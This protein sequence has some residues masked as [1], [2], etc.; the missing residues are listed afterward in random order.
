MRMIKPYG[1]SETTLT[2]GQ[3][4]RR[5]LRPNTP[6]DTPVNI[7]EYAKTHPE[8]IIAQWISAI[9]KIAAKPHGDKKP[10]PEQRQFRQRL[11][12]AAFEV[13]SNQN[14]LPLPDRKDEL[15]GLWWSKIHPYGKDDDT[16]KSG[17]EK[18]RWYKRF[19]GG[20][21]PP[22]ADPAAIAEKI[23]KHLHQQE[24][25]IWPDRPDKRRGRIEARA[26]SIAESVPALP[27]AF[28][29]GEHPWS[30]KDKE[31]YKTAGNIAHQIKLKHEARKKQEEER[32]FSMRDAAPILFEQYGRLF[33]D[34]NGKALPVAGARERFP[35]LFALHSAV[36]D[37]YARILETHRPLTGKKSVTPVFPPDM[38]ALFRLLRAKAD[39]R[40]LNA[41]TRLGKLIH[42]QATPSSG[43]DAPG[44]V[45]DHWPADVEHSQ[46]RTSAG[47]AEIKRHEAFVRVWRNTIALAARTLKDWADPDG[48]IG[49]DILLQIEKAIK[50]FRASAY[51]KKL[52]LLFGNRSDLFKGQDEDFQK[53]VLRLALKGWADLRNASFHFKGR[54]SFVSAL[55]ESPEEPIAVPAAHKL[56]KCDLQERRD[57]LIAVLRAAHVEY[58]FDQNRLKALIGAVV[59]AEP[60]ALPPP[61]P[62]FRRVLDRAKKAWDRKP[63]VLHLPP[64]DNRA[65]LEKPGRQCRYVVTKTLYE[66]GFP[67]W[68]EK[69]SAD[70]LN[71]WIER[72]VERTTKAAR[73][74]NKDQRA[75]ARA[76]GLIHLVEGQGIAHFIDRLSAETATELRVQRGYDSDPDRARKQAKYLDD[77]RCDV[78]GQAF[79]DYLD[80][81][82]LAW[83]LDDLSKERPETKCSTLPEPAA[84]P[85]QQKA[86]DWEAVL[87]FLLHLVPVD[88]IGRLQH[89]LRK[90]S[91]LENQASAEAE[92]AGR[93][94]SLYLDMHDA[95]FEGSE[96]V[97]G[98][99]ALKGLFQSDTFAKACP[100]QPGQDAGRYVPWRGLREIL[101]FGSLGPLMP[102]FKQHPITAE[103]VDELMAEEK[104]GNGE[105]GLSLIATHQAKREELHNEWTRKKGKKGRFSEQNKTAYR[106]AL[107]KVVKHRQLAAHVRLN[108]HNRLHKL[109]M[110][111]LGR[112]VDYAGLWERDL[113]FTTLALIWLRKKKPETIFNS[114]GRKAVKNGQIVKALRTFLNSQDTDQRAIFCQLQRLFGN[115]FLD[116]E[117]GVVRVRNDLA[118]F[119]ML[120]GDPP[121]LN[122]TRT[123]NHTRR[124][125]AYDRKLK[126]A[127][128]QS[129]KEMLAREGLNLTWTMQDHDLASATITPRQAVH[130]EDTEIRENLHG[131][132]FVKMVAALFNGKAQDPD[133]ADILSLDNIRQGGQHTAGR[134]TY[135]RAGNTRKEDE[136]PEQ[137]AKKA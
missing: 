130:L 126:N 120:Q 36:K 101:R 110:E 45:I 94:F 119:N 21:K 135:G 65:E 26:E 131:K 6:G 76:A 90:W 69:Q 43:A 9:D 78:V 132:Q 58:Y 92:G 104:P 50:E 99:E 39:N 73:T 85:P 46:Y 96:G 31:Q 70:T 55:K 97:A 112:L 129:I 91:I 80:D 134:A 57:R 62:R 30:D 116:R 32:G 38:E 121:S 33:K 11:G 17:W 23:R 107:K 3:Q 125:M 103:E 137:Q 109:L 66:R 124:L 29:D 95:K 75:V 117:N 44:N 111:V 13:L 15:E 10:T 128:S 122:L 5:K 60:S 49:R 87:Y 54:R 47:Q 102:V 83:T 52:S 74:T 63:Y 27:P 84:D 35:G 25:R 2:H 71:E 4:P 56:L 61:L 64:P 98:A 34:D 51:D 100:E 59:N 19:A 123:V 67:A 22:Q 88:T 89:Q 8:L 86:E 40:D 136:K 105:G 68:L 127:V 81:A 106:R 42:Y 48:R 37:A 24:Y 93:L 79:K 53:S 77:L 18:G 108:N 113:Y 7:V 82:D 133:K 12:E 115:D 41:L 16:E 28:P 72:A 20:T 1:R 118:H 14:L 114:K